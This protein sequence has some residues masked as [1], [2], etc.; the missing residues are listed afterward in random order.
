MIVGVPRETFPGERRVALVPIVIPNLAKAGIEAASS[1]PAR[2]SR[3]AI[4]TPSTPRKAPRLSPTAR[5]SLPHADI[6][7]QVLCYGSNDQTG[8][9]DLPLIRRDQVLDRFPAAPGLAGNDSGDR[10]DGRDFLLR[11]TDAAN[12]ARA[13]HGR[14][15]VD[16]ARSAVTRPC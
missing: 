14:A 9:A 12:H 13:E 10:R 3:P 8:H 6:V 5:M 15:F 2:A 11:G 1:K 4:R 16:G 7:T